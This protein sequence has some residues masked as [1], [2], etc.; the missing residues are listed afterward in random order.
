MAP[1]SAGA[2]ALPEG[3]SQELKQK[4]Q[5]VREFLIAL[6]GGARPRARRSPPPPRARMAA[7][8]FSAPRA[9]PSAPRAAPARPGGWARATGAE[10]LRSPAVRGRLA[11]ARARA[12]PAIVRARAPLTHLL[13][14]LVLRAA[15][16]ANQVP[17][18][19]I[20]NS[21]SNH[22]GSTDD[23]VQDLEQQLERKFPV[24]AP[25]SGGCAAF[26]AGSALRRY[27]RRVRSVP[28]V[29]AVQAR[30]GKSSQTRRRRRRQTARVTTRC[31][32]RTSSAHEPRQSR[33][34]RAVFAS[35]RLSEAHV[36][37]VCSWLSNRINQ[38]GVAVIR[39]GCAVAVRLLRAV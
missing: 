27:V 8:R 37:H 22:G 20:L 15:E 36:T 3:T 28:G 13:C 10:G 35:A 2:D 21:L 17:S 14:K 18:L 11:G 25:P 39:V 38:R 29:C 33:R 26:L 16:S 30:R 32:D 23:A 6:K 5:M 4:V 31:G 7:S 19:E 9:A 12:R 34:K 24:C 1:G